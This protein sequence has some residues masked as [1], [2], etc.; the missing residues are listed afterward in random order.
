MKK[1]YYAAFVPNDGK[2]S[3]FFPDFP[4]LHPWHETMEL[5][6]QDAMDGLDLHLEGMADDGDDIPE[7]SSLEEARAV[8]EKRF[9]EIGVTP[10]EI[11]WQLVPAPDLSEQQARVNVSFKRYTLD[12]IDRKAEAAGMT[13]SGFLAAAA[14]AFDAERLDR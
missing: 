5:A 3:V 13:R 6:F 12:M 10:F 7:P 2:V 14:R 1:A 11:V 9:A 4:G 8:M